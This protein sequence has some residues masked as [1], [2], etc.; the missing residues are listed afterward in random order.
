MV[1]DRVQSECH[2]EAL[3]WAPLVQDRVADRVLQG[4]K[5]AG[6]AVETQHIFK[7]SIFY[8]FSN[9]EAYLGLG[10]QHG[11]SIEVTRFF[12]ALATTLHHE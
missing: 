6:S 2:F 3:V 8:Y 9:K 10:L 7:F 11:C 12:V 1:V 5:F 4:G